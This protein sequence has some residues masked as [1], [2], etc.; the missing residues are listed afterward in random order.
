M[1][2]Q[3]QKKPLISR[4]KNIPLT[5]E[6]SVAGDKSISHRSL[7]FA[8]LAHGESKITGLLEGE[9]V[10]KTAASL[11]LMVVEI[12]KKENCWLV[13]G[14]GVAGLTEP[15]DVLD[16]GNSGTAARLLAGLVA[17]YN[18]TSFFSGDDSLRKRPMGRVF[19]PIQQFG[20][21]IISRKNGLMPFAIIGAKDALPIAYKMKLASA[22][23]KSCILL[24][25]LATRAGKMSRPYRNHDASFGA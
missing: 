25:S 3:P 5:G 23:V 8:A 9:D 20:A 7:I 11:R 21:Q 13:N 2:P 14:S 17:P 4:K 24:A 1:I 19:E 6:I 16:M 18:F 12:E 15:S 10:L 22:Q